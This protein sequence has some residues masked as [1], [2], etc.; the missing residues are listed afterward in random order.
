[1]Q[2]LWFLREVS[3]DG[4]QVASLYRV[5][6]PAV[7]PVLAQ[8]RQLL[9]S[10]GPVRILCVVIHIDDRQIRRARLAGDNS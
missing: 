1:M 2:T 8:V 4:G 5:D 7:P 9:L 6:E 10:R 3:L